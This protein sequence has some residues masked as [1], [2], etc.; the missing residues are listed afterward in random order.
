MIETLDEAY[1]AAW[2]GLEAAVL[3]AKH[4]FHLASVATVGP[5][6]RPRSRVVVLRA[7][8]RDPGE[9]RF[10]TDI[11]SA[12]WD[13]MQRHPSVAWLFYDADARLQVR[14]EGTV[15]LH[16]GSDVAEEAWAATRLLS[17][18][19]YTAPLAPGTLSSVPTSGLPSELEGREPTEE[20][21][22]AGRERFGVVVG[23]VE[24]LDVYS[25]AFNGHRRAHFVREGE[26]WRGE[27]RVP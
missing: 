16:T 12:K 1:R 22:A 8:F 19:C 21:S 14:A 9:L 24:E 18:R 10:H 7:A 11:R 25:L 2:E 20:E 13:E 6:R 26:G 5:D 27:W 17:R 4:P 3:S 15:E 23:R